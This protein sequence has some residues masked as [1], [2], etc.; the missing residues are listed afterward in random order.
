[1]ARYR[2]LKADRMKDI[3]H[4]KALTTRVRKGGKL[5]MNLD[6]SVRCGRRRRLILKCD[7]QST[8]VVDTLAKKP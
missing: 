5:G 6:R 1:M 3:Q 7:M 4:F 8:P 2:R